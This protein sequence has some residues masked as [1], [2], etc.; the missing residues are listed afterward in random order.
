M[1]EAEVQFNT[2]EIKQL[3][4]FYYDL[5]DIDKRKVFLASFRRAGKTLVDVVKPQVPRRTGNLV[6]SIGIKAVGRES[7]VDIGA[8]R[9]GGKKGWHGHIIENG[10]KERFRK[11]QKNASTGRVLPNPIWERSYNDN[12]QKMLEQIRDEWFQVVYEFGM[13]RFKKMT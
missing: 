5:S 6:N 10:T 4:A 13:R 3:E 11:T 8:F 9:G 2:D 12:E 7:S 1:A